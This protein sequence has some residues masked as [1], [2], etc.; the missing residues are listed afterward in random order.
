MTVCFE[1]AGALKPQYFCRGLYRTRH[2]NRTQTDPFGVL[3]NARKYL[4]NIFK[5]NT[6]TQ[7]GIKYIYN[8]K[9]ELSS[10]ATPV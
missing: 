1:T 7:D 2:L 8:K 3:N 6:S 5:T 10:S 4:P 9:G